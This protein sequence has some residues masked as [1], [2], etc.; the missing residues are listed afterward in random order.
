MAD[1]EPL[2][3]ARD[4]AI[5]YDRTP[6]LEGVSGQVL[7]GESV[8][9]IG[10]NGAGK[11]TLLKAVLGLVPVVGGSITV[12]GRTPAAARREVA[13]VPQAAALDPE[14][15]ISAGQVVLM[16]RYPKVGWV[17]RPGR[18]DRATAAAALEAVGLADQAGLRFGALSGG[19]RQRVLLARAMAQ[20]ARLLLLDEP[21]TGV[22]ATS[23]ELLVAALARAR[24]DGAAVLISTHDLALAHVTSDRV[25]LLNRRQFG[26]GPVRDT[27]TPERLQATYGARAG[28]P[29]AQR[30]AMSRP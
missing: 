12:L 8:A 5:A 27:L 11:T 24:D 22:D 19:Q 7:A 2:L 15:P 9:L 23:E 10:P 26:F 29:P 16:G 13:Y 14:F 17:R 3:V 20:E 1:P 30:A 25:W 4:V 6:V 21:F 28:E 18:A